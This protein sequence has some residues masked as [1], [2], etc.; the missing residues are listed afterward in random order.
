MKVP[1]TNNTPPMPALNRVE[2]QLPQ[3]P[4]LVAKFEEFYSQVVSLKSA[5]GRNPPNSP[6]QTTNSPG[7]THSAHQTEQSLLNLLNSQEARVEREETLLGAEMYRQ[8]Q[9]VM[10]CLADEIFS[11]LFRH[12][13]GWPSLERALFGVKPGGLSAGGPCL[14]KLDQLLIQDDPVYRE[15]ASVYFYALALRGPGHADTEKYLGPLHEMIAGSPAASAAA[16]PAFA[17][18]YAH[19]LSEIKTVFLPS[20][21]KWLL[22]F[23]L[24]LLAW[25]VLSTV[26]WREVRNP[27]ADQL[28]KIYGMLWR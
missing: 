23:A 10:A 22:A 14:Q 9:H 12:V 15:L 5:V 16:D 28:H 6:S 20:A 21:R 17:Q 24:I 19:T 18:S 1:A 4:F 13:G 25:A 2:I 27:I 7:Q 11:P 3:D 8:A 26:L